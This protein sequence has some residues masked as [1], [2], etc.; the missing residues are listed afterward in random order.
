MTDPNTVMTPT[1]TPDA[2]TLNTRAEQITGLIRKLT[3]TAQDFGVFVEREMTTRRIKD[4]VLRD[5]IVNVHKSRMADCIAVEDELKAALLA[6]A[7]SPPDAPGGALAITDIGN[8]VI[9]AA[10][11]LVD[12]PFDTQ[13]ERHEAYE[14]LER[15][16][17]V[18]QQNAARSRATETE[19]T[20]A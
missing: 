3:V 18:Y 1:P 5:A 2:G 7:P 8:D 16:V 9:Y 15:A 6:L 13:S 11:H 12:G 14:D 17:V 20:D 4:K 19:A 10:E